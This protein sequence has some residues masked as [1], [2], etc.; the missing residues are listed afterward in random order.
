MLVLLKEVID[1]Q[2][3]LRDRSVNPECVTNVHKK[4]DHSTIVEL[5]SGEFFVAYGS[6]AE[7]TRILN[8]QKRVLKG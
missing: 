1:G 6:V 7:V 8:K 3:D 2:V 4:G 5:S